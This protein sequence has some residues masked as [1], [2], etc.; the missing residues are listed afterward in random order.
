MEH[1][2]SDP[3]IRLAL[4]PLLDF[5]AEAALIEAARMDVPDNVAGL[6]ARDHRQRVELLA[7]SIRD[8][9]D[10]DQRVY[11]DGLEL[12][13]ELDESDIVHLYDAFL[14]MQENS[15]PSIDGLDEEE[16]ELLKKVL[17]EIPWS[18]LSGRSWYAA[19]R[20]LGALSQDGVLP[21]SL[22]GS[23][24]NTKSITTSE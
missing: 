1:L 24:S 15:N 14:E 7:S 10:L 12:Q 17:Q 18:D 21:D 5:E 23:T 6:M 20:F 8:P 9:K 11:S 3:E 4:V 19:K 16:F 13:K 2:I 22:R